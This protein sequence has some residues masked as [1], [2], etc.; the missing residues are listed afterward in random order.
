MF[1][2]HSRFHL[3]AFANFVIVLVVIAALA[4][5]FAVHLAVT[6]EGQLLGRECNQAKA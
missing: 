6:V 4:D 2:A 5:T 1:T 3:N